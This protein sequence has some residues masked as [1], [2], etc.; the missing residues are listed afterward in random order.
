MKINSIRFSPQLKKA[1]DYW[2]RSGWR[3]KTL[4]MKVWRI[5]K[6]IHTRKATCSILQKIGEVS[7][8]NSVVL[9]NNLMRK[10]LTSVSTPWRKT[11]PILLLKLMVI[12][13]VLMSLATMRQH[14]TLISPERCPM[15]KVPWQK[16]SRKLYMSSSS[17][18]MIKMQSYAGPS[19][20]P[21]SPL[22]L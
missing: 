10:S 2:R 9:H 1:V 19:K 21:T 15:T 7:K 8:N 17:L 22:S 13:Q 11:R 3:K 20:N 18:S 5:V 14:S 12:N 4:K 16:N 6:R